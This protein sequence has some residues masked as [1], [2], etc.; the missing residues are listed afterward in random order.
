M[1]RSVCLATVNRKLVTDRIRSVAQN[2]YPRIFT[3]PQ[4][5]GACIRDGTGLPVLVDQ[6]NTSS[7]FADPS[8]DY[9]QWCPKESTHLHLF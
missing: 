7:L 5:P 1:I 4:N 9:I 6:S 8:T 3:D 2:G